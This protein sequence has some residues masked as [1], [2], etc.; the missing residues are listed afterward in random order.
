MT[1]IKKDSST[2]GVKI[3]KDRYYRELLR[4]NFLR[5]ALTYLAPLILLTGYFCAQFAAITRE[6][7]LLHLK[8]VAEHQANTLDLFLRE[9][10]TNVA[11]LI[12]DP[13]LKLPPSPAA[14]EA[15]LGRLQSSS[16]TFV[17]VG[18]FD[19]TGIQAAYAGPLPDLEF[20]N[21]SE[22]PWFVTL[23]SSP[24]NFIITDNYLG[25][26]QQPHFTIGVSRN[27]GGR[28]VVL[29]ATLDPARFYNYISS[30]EGTREV[31]MATVNR[32]G[33]YQIVTP[34]MGTPLESSSII[35]PREPRLGIASAEIHGMKSTYAYVWLRG[36]NWAVIVQQAKPGFSVPF[37]GGLT[38]ILGISFALILLVL[39][40]IV[41]R[42]K[43][44]VELQI[45][46]ETTKAQFEHAAKLASVGELSAGIAHEINNPLAIIS[47]EAGLMKDLMNP[48]FKTDTTFE[49]LQPHLA[50]IHDA[51]F[52]CRDI[53]RKL[54]S[55]VRKTDIQIKLQDV[56]ILLDEI[57]DGF[58]IQEMAV[59]NIN[60]VRQ[61]DR[62]IPM[63][64]TDANQ[65]KQVFLNILNNAADAIAPPGQ[66]SI[67]TA[68]DDCEISVAIA[69][70]G[71]GI[72][73]EQ[74]E[75]I[76]MPFYTTKE[77]GKG[78]GLGLSVSYSIV[79]SLGGKIQVESIPGQGS[80]FTIILPIK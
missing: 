24:D 40:I 14:M 78:T 49:D 35:P 1:E 16:E 33:F 22:E 36:A 38:S 80:V 56:N 18:F 11:N 7:E 69:D 32:E 8:S 15:M 41:F 30:L 54:L 66:I 12:D 58:W 34:Q 10:V 75:R 67:T 51:V 68:H 19:S 45:E 20:R 52:R 77:V 47:E 61:Y 13:R 25:L 28:Y 57:V 39:A 62:T 50:N 74:I 48:E 37:V 43:K 26:R 5:L 76:F 31:N 72:S 46:R 27:I 70:T 79:K 2:V 9:R 71:R 44:L 60:I 64:P 53:T 21:Y 6:S 42:S 63:I 17:D 3:L 29:R 55:F 65:L 4:R 59:S 73:E 23:Q